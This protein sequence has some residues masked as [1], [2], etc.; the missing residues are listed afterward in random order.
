MDLARALD[1]SCGGAVGP[2]DRGDRAYLH[3]CRRSTAVVGAAAVALS[4]DLG[5]A[6]PVAPASAGQMDADG[7]AA[8]DRRG[9]RAARVRRRTE[10][11]ADARRPSTLFFCH[12][13]GLSWRAGA[14]P[15]GR[16]ISHR[17][18]CGAVVR[19]HGWRPGRLV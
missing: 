5:A 3:R 11:A 18:L 8:G 1:R 6:V 14:Y 16:E 15:P 12:C 10:P 19:R 4:L 13:D 9:D 7:P 2:A 17:L